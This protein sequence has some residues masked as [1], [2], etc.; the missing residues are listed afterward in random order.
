MPTKANRPIVVLFTP[1]SASHVPSVA[2]VNN[3]GRPE[4]KPIGRKM[5][6]LFLKHFFKSLIKI[7][8]FKNVIF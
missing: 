3:R 2:D 8:I 5:S 1:R 4:K 6:S 7:L